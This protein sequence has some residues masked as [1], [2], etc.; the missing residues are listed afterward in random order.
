MVL[1]LNAS[2]PNAIFKLPPLVSYNVLYPMARL[3]LSTTELYSDSVPI[4]MFS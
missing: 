1:Y 4:A 2:D 3:E